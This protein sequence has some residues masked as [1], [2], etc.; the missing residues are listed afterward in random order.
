MSFQ[1]IFLILKREYLT[2][3]KSKSFILATLLT[4][5]AFIAMFA[6]VIL[7]SLSDTEVQQKIGII[8]NTEM[9]YNRLQ[10]LSQNRYV[11]ISN[12]EMDSVRAQVLDGNLG[13]YIIL[14]EAVIR[15]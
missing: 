12:L 8:D 1:K 2:K 10:E 14:D 5:L 4:P 6:I 9:L 7:V 3:V 11:D 13:G 15:E